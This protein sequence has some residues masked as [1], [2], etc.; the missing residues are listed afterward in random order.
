MERKER[1]MALFLPSTSS[2]APVRRKFLHPDSK[3]LSV[4][5]V[6]VVRPRSSNDLFALDLHQLMRAKL[7]L[8]FCLLSNFAKLVESRSTTNSTQDIYLSGVLFF[9]NCVSSISTKSHTPRSS[10]PTRSQNSTQ[11][12]RLSP[13]SQPLKVTRTVMSNEASVECEQLAVR[14]S[15][16]SAEWLTALNKYKLQRKTFDMK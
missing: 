6:L 11:G 10:S 16:D 9:S 12:G 14:V 5:S 15:V 13:P 2:T 1:R 8:F 4:P 3:L 7:Y